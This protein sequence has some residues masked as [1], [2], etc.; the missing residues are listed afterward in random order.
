MAWPVLFYVPNL[1]GYSRI[2][3]TLVAFWNAENLDRF[4]KLYLIGFLLDAADGYAA[5]LLRQSSEFGAVLDMITDRVSTAGLLF[6]L[7]RRQ[8]SLVTAGNGATATCLVTWLLVALYMFLVLLDAVSHFW[9]V[10]A[11]S[12]IQA[13][14]HKVAGA[15][16]LVRLYYRRSVLTAVCLFSELFLLLQLS[17]DAKFTVLN[18]GT[19]TGLMMSVIYLSCG[20]VY[21]LKQCISLAQISNAVTLLK[22]SIRDQNQN[23]TR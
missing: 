15:K 20:A 14:S 18:F 17:W 1:I 2:G 12:V 3:L 11:A 5:R 4:V 16:R 22:Q 21:V 13:S 7:A 23:A 6:L 9:Q 8:V 10:C 19:V